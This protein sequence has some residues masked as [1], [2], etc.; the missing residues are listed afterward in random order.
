MAPKI[1]FSGNTAV[2][3]AEGTSETLT[4]KSGII[5]KLADCTIAHITGKVEPKE[6]KEYQAEVIILPPSQAEKIITKIKPK[7]AILTAGKDTVYIARELQ[8]KTGIQTIA[9]KDNLT[10]DL[11][12]YSA[13]AE[14]KPL[15]KFTEAK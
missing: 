3:K 13:M 11:Y 14:Q 1:Y 8:K 9:A 5:Y 6:I 4:K 7:L 2:I 12:A 10:V 15:S